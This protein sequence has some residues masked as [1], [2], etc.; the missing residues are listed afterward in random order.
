MFERLAY[1]GIRTVLPV[2]IMQADDP[3]GL[4]LTAAHKGTI[5][6]WWFVFQSILPM[7]TG[8]YA[9]RYGYKRVLAF[10]LSMIA[11][12]YALMAF[13]H[14]YGGFFAAVVIL[15]VGTAFFKPSLKGGLAQGLDKGNSSLGWGVFYWIANVGA[16]LAPFISTLILGDPHTRESWTNVFLMSAGFSCLNLILLLTFRDVPS[17]ADKTEST[18]VVLRRTI[19]NFFQPRLVA[20][21]LIISAFYTMM[22]QLWDLQPNFIVDWVDSTSIAE[23]LRLLPDS[24]YDRITEQTMGHRRV[25]QQVL[26]SINPALV[27]CLVIPLAWLMRKMRTLSAMLIGMSVAILGVLLAGLT[28]N[29]WMLIAGITCFSMGEML[30][31]PKKIEYLGLIAPSGRKGMYLGYVS[32]PAGLGGVAGSK[33]AAFLYGNYGEKAT[34]ALRYL[35]EHTS[36]KGNQNWDGS[37]A[38]LE[39]ALGVSRTDAMLKLQEV[40][41]LDATAA[42]NLLWN[43]YQPQYFVWLPI[44][45]MGV[46]AAAAMAVFGHRAKRWADMDA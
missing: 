6:A 4:H 10:S 37:V 40:L 13:A 20:F 33:L 18:L 42:T 3:G 12:G 19:V 32:L 14:S 34:L 25:A 7:L 45:A 31:G 38:S 27:V 11:L 24:I 30:T 39:T 28:Q 44:V 21:L 41:G 35:A 2:Y 26:L 5:Y 43:T 16:L 22:F 29:G 46:L 9:D 36:F 23:K 1:F 8:G 17:G 15:A